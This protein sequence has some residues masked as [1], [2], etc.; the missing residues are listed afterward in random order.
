MISASKY[1]VLSHIII[2]GEGQNDSLNRDKIHIQFMFAIRYCV[3]TVSYSD[4]LYR[5]NA[6]SLRNVSYCKAHSIRC[7]LLTLRCA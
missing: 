1:S 6:Y 3:N 7:Y 2:T 4:D 5:N